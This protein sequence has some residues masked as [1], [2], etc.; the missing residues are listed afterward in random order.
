M[1]QLFSILLL[2]MFIALLY[3]GDMSYTLSFEALQ[4]WFEKLVPSMFAVMVMVKILFEQGI[5]HRLSF[6][7]V[8]LFR[9]L[10][11]IEKNGVPFVISSIF[12]GFPAGANFINEQVSHT[13]LNKQEGQRLIYTCSFAT[14]GF[15][16]LSCGSLLFHSTSIGFQL[17]LIQVL[18]GLCLLFLTRKQRIIATNVTYSSPSFMTSLR[19]SILESGKTLYMIGGYLML[20]MSMTAILVQFLPTILQLPL[21]IIAEFSSGTMLL[22]S[23][24]LPQKTC[25]ILLSMLLSFGGFCVHMQVISMANDSDLSYLKYLLFR[26]LQSLISMFLAIL[27]F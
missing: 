1:K 13:I 19:S 14:P 15:V 24:A 12:L 26:M 8:F 11:Q 7:F 22:Y 18:S 23:L 27:F 3:Y 17:F 4:I 5:L 25:L 20:C 21:R 10:F 2:C 9:H 6:P 16:I